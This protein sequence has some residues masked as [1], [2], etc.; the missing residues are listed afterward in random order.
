MIIMH[1]SLCYPGK[2]TWRMMKFIVSLYKID[3]IKYTCEN[4]NKNT[5]YS[6]KEI[7]T[8]NHIKKDCKIKIH[9][10]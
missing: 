8:Q 3:S 6:L 5:L 7:K 4:P 9:L 1:G 10:L 2:M